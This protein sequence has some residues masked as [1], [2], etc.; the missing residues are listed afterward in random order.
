MR[1]AI[2]TNSH[3]ILLF[4][5][6]KKVLMSFFYYFYFDSLRKTLIDE[7]SYETEKS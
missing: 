7:K 3:Q 6:K 5:E 2:K 4:Q 1:V